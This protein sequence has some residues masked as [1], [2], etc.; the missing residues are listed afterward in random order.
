MPCRYVFKDIWLLRQ[1]SPT[2]MHCQ[3]SSLSKRA[4]KPTQIHM[5]SQVDAI[6][7]GQLRGPSGPAVL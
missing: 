6:M 4:S 3:R 5:H 2:S 1:V 7:S